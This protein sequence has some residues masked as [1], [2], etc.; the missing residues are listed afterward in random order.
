MSKRASDLDGFFEWSYE[1]TKLKERERR[2]HKDKR[3]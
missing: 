3:E 1:G 2:K